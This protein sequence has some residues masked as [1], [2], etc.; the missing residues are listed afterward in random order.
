MLTAKCP[1]CGG[2]VQVNQNDEA[3]ICSQ[4]KKPFIT[5]KAINDYIKMN[6]SKDDNLQSLIRKAETFKKLDQLSK[7]IEIYEKITDD[8][9]EELVG[10]LSLLPYRALWGWKNSF[11]RPINYIK[12][13]EK[14]CNPMNDNTHNSIKEIVIKQYAEVNRIPREFWEY[15][16]KYCDDYLNEGAKK[17][18]EYIESK[19]QCRESI[20]FQEAI[21]STTFNAFTVPVLFL[22]SKADNIKLEEKNNYLPCILNDL[23]RLPIP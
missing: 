12:T 3:S 20:Y 22:K 13:I 21:L 17:A 16:M 4:C 1:H 19:R 6:T 10:W 11:G 7:A 18:N 23:L 9:P 8:Y 5:E 2:I 15:T 14:L